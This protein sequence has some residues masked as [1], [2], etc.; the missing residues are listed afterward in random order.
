[1]YNPQLYLRTYGNNPTIVTSMAGAYLE[2]DPQ[3][4]Y[5]FTSNVLLSNVAQELFGSVAW[6]QAY[7]DDDYAN[8]SAFA[9]RR[10]L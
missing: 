8:N 3:Q 6:F 1:M 2:S 9:G 5:S 7:S 10:S 4:T